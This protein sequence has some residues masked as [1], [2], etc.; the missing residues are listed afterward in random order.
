MS[1][2]MIFAVFDARLFNSVDKLQFF[3]I[4]ICCL[5]SSA[6]LPEGQGL[7]FV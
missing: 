6:N 1:L 3:V 4:Y 5:A 7:L 2:F